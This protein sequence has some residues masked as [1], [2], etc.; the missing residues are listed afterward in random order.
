MRNKHKKELE[1]LKVGKLSADVTKVIRQ[2]VED[3]SQKY[4]N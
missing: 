1:E 4:D 3:L 2:V